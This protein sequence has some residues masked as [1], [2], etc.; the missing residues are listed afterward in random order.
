MYIVIVCFPEYDVINFEINVTFNNELN[1][2]KTPGL[3]LYLRYSI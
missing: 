2:Y 1:P 3:I